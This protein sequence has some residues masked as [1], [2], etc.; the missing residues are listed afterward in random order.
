MNN[1]INIQEELNKTSEVRLLDPYISRLKYLTY[2][3]HNSNQNDKKL[4]LD[5][6]LSTISSSTFDSKINNVESSFSLIE[7]LIELDFD[8]SFSNEFF[9]EIYDILLG[10]F[11]AKENESEK[12][13]NMLMKMIESV[14]SSNKITYEKLDQI[15]RKAENQFDRND[16]VVG[17]LASMANVSLI[18]KEINAN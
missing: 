13:Q 11:Y 3:A 2:I 17:K 6:I 7:Y 5:K 15:Y 8:T 12:H 16:I 9:N 1:L 14:I 4:M 18:K 10:K